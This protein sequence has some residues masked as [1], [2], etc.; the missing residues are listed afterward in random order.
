MCVCLRTESHKKELRQIRL[1]GSSSCIQ[2][3]PVLSILTDE[4]E[5]NDC[6]LSSSVLVPFPKE[7]DDQK[8]AGSEYISM[9]RNNLLSSTNFESSLSI[10]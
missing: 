2:I 6:L 4:G 9:S 1:Q 8:R 3:G 10:L 7:R 5:S